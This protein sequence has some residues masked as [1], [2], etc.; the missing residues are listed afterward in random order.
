MFNYQ[1]GQ[2][3]ING[4]YWNLSKWEIVVVERGGGTLPESAGH[5]YVK[6]PLRR[7]E[8]LWVAAP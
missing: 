6:L 5:R 7:C 4:L 2:K 3:V 8:I 1:G